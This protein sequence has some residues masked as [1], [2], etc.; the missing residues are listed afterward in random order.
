MSKILVALAVLA[1]GAIEENSKEV[2][3][4]DTFEAPDNVAAMLVESSQAKAFVEVPEGKRIKAR[5]LVES[6]HGKPGEV[7]TM[8]A[9]LAQSAQN[10][11]LVDAHPSAVAYAERE[12][13]KAE[14]RAQDA[15]S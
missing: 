5:V 14:Q 11:G 3:V 4:G 13:R 7:V 1:A 8:P 12:L 10:A 6:E 15:L 2:Q 9:D